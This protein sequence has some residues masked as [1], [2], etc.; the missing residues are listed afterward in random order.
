MPTVWSGYTPKA[1]GKWPGAMRLGLKVFTDMIHGICKSIADM[2]FTKL[3]MLDCHGQHAPMLNMVTKLIADEYDFYYTVAT[4]FTFSAKEFNA[5]RKSPR[6]CCSHACEW[7]TSLIM[8][9]SPELVHPEK[10]CS[11]DAIRHHSEFIAGDALLGGQK[12]VWSSFGI[13][14]PK[15]GALGDPSEA[16][17]ETGRVIVNAIRS[18]FK[19]YLNEYYFHKKIV[20][21]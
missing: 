19:K 5:V 8:L 20:I 15:Y 14:Q 10:F 7:E 16:S 6:G 13:Q 2:G 3:L 21:E 1:I 4:P 9:I 12:V 11:D 18:N 17:A